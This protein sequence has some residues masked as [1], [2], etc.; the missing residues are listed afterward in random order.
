MKEIKTEVWEDS[1][2]ENER[3][4]NKYKYLMMDLEEECKKIKNYTNPFK[5]SS[6]KIFIFIIIVIVLMISI[7]LIYLLSDVSKLPILFLPLYVV[8]CTLMLIIVLFWLHR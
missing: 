1:I 5:F 3:I 2:K 8:A 7:G 4:K 6:Y